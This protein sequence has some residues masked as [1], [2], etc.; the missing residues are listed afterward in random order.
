[1]KKY[2]TTTFQLTHNLH[3]EIKMMCVL[4]NKTMGEFIRL[5]LIEKIN[6]LK[7]GK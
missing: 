4:T 5:C 7:N 2:T 1:M 6:E 3:T